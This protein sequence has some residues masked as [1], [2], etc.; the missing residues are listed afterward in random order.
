[1]WLVMV[2]VMVM[3]MVTVMVMVMLID[4]DLQTLHDPEPE[5]DDDEDDQSCP[6]WHHIP[7][8][9]MEGKSDCWEISKDFFWILF[10]LCEGLNEYTRMSIV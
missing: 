4:N 2:M 6:A 8:A 7:E 10:A 3:V 5:E 1:M 9:G